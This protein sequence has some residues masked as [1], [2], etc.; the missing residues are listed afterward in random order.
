[1]DTATAFL[2]ADPIE[3]QRGIT[4]FSGQA[5]FL[6]RGRQYVLVDTPGHTDFASEMERAL[7]VLDA[8]VVVVSAAEGVQGHTEVILRLLARRNIPTLFFVNKLDRAGADAGR[9]FDQLRKLCTGEII[10]FTGR[11]EANE[12]TPA[13]AE[14]LAALDEPLLEQYVEEGYDAELWQRRAAEMVRQRKLHPA[15]CGAALEGRG[16]A[17]LLGRTACPSGYRLRM[18][19]G[20][21]AFRPRVSGAPR[22]QRWPGALSQAA[23][24]G[25]FGSKGELAGDKIDEIRLYHGDKY[26]PVEEAEAGA[27]CAVTGVSG[28]KPGQTIDR[29]QGAVEDGTSAVRPVMQARRYGGCA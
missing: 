26:H 10:D 2:D 22:R 19:G 7:A 4:I 25:G 1:M 6:Y 13:L 29:A 21:A 3:R 5:R 27:L 18:P 23:V 14:E 17:E 12:M 15:F 16:V 24:P 9:V 28:L 20:A 8:A 11:L